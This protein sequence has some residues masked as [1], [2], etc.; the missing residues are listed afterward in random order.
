[1]PSYS[2]KS[3]TFVAAAVIVWLLLSN[4]GSLKIDGVIGPSTVNKFKSG[5]YHE[6]VLDSSGGSVGSAISI[7]KL[8]ESKT[9]KVSVRGICLSACAEFIIPSSSSIKTSQRSMIGFHWSP[10][11]DKH[12]FYENIG[13]Q[14]HCF[15]DEISDF[16]EKLLASNGLDTNFWRE[17]E[18]RLDLIHYSIPAGQF[19]CRKEIRRTFRNHMWLPT[20]TQLRELWNLDLEGKLC[21]DNFIRCS[22]RADK[23]WQSG[24][25]I[26]IGDK[27]HVSRGS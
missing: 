25:R 22:K 16:Q 1:M 23:L 6:I 4:G 3:L 17:V 27:V 7:A 18:K 14:E 11:M 24:T 13:S 12:Q 21:A 20:T 8:L 15:P 2:V 5:A 10:L 26:V 19:N 9:V